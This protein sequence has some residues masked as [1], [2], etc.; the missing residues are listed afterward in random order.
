MKRNCE[1]TALCG[2]S[3]VLTTISDTDFHSQTLWSFL[4]V[5]ISIDGCIYLEL[6]ELLT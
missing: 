1:S 6:M 4:L 2:A 5:D 3:V